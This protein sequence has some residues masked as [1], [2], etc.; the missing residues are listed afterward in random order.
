[1]AVDNPSVIDA[2]GV[3]SVT[4]EVVLMIADHLEWDDGYEHLVVLQEKINCYLGFI[5]SGE[6]AEAYPQSAGRPVRIA[7][8]CK[9][10]PTADGRRFLSLASETVE[11]AGVGFTW[12]FRPDRPS[13]DV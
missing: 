7:V 13:G 11:A 12:C 4:G 3:S 8:Y 5:E 2:A 10:A 6:I 9:H 1:M